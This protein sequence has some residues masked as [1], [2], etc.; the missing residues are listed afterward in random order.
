MF[1]EL[2]QAVKAGDAAEGV[3]FDDRMKLAEAVL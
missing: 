3:D 2:W 1:I